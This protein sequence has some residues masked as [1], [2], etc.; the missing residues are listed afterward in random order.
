MTKNESSMLLAFMKKYFPP[1]QV[2]NR[3]FTNSIS[4]PDNEENRELVAKA[5]EDWAWAKSI[6]IRREQEYLIVYEWPLIVYL[7]KQ[8]EQEAGL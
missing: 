6:L 7:R 8:F 3:S 2:V 1:S 4:I 5:E